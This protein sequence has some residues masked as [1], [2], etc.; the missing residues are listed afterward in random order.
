MV[1]ARRLM[2]YSLYV[3]PHAVDRMGGPNLSP[4]LPEEKKKTVKVE[5]HPPQHKATPRALIGSIFQ[6]TPRLLVS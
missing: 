6:P 2:A 1:K 3:Y 5:G 4:S